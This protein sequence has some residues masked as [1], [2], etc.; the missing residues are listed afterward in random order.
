MAIG[1]RRPPQPVGETRGVVLKERGRAGIR[2]RRSV[3]DEF[4]RP[5][6]IAHSG[7]VEREV[8]DD[9]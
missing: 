1:V 4:V 2:S 6:E 9:L 8:E 7:I 3:D 5:L